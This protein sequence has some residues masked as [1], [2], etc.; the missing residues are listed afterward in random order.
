MGD[1][2]NLRVQ[3]LQSIEKQHVESPQVYHQPDVS[4]VEVQPLHLF[5][6]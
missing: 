2:L 4:I 1:Q 5:E 3:D 6:G